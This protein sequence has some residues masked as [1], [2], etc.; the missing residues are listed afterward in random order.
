[1]I[2]HLID[3]YIFFTFIYLCTKFAFGN[4][5]YD[6]R[7][8]IILMLINVINVLLSDYLVFINYSVKIN[9][10]IYVFLH[11][12]TWLFLILNITKIKNIDKKLLLFIYFVFCLINFIFFEGL[13]KFNTNFFIISSI[14]YV[15]YYIIVCF[16]KLK[17]ENFD[18]FLSNNF[19]LITSPLFFFIGLSFMFSFK[20]K[21]LTTFIIF[22]NLKLY[23]LINYFVNII[24][25]TLINIYIFR[26][27]K[28]QNG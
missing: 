26:E 25:Y 13:D 22:G 28:Q 20:S 8:L 15:L 1:M 6:Y 4:K 9:S 19:I 12:F 16:K 27:R 24:Y 5:F 23:T 2:L 17:T 14:F 3:F 21:D 10:N 18:F 7:F 11:N